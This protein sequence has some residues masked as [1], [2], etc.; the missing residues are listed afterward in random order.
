MKKVVWTALAA[1]LACLCVTATDASAQPRQNKAAKRAAHALQEMDKNGDKVI[2]R[3]EW[4]RK[5]KAFDR[6]DSNHDGKITA[7]E[8]A[9]A[10]GR[11]RHRR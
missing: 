10:R 3:D 4:T 1:S 9:A 11:R 6:L 2:T 5:A 8:L 7:D